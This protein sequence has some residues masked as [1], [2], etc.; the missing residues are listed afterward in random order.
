M[1]I[2]LVLCLL[3]GLYVGAANSLSY[4]PYE[5]YAYQA[6]TGDVVPLNYMK[7]CEPGKSGEENASYV[8][9]GISYPFPARL[10]VAQDFDGDLVV[11]DM[12]DGLPVRVVKPGAFLAC[13]KLKSVSLPGSLREVGDNAFGWCLSLT[14]VTFKSGLNLVGECA[15][16]NCV[17]LTSISFPPTLKKLGLQCF[18]KCNSLEDVYF[19][20]NA[21]QVDPPTKAL[22][23]CLGE[24]LY[25]SASPRSRLRVHVKPVSE[26][27]IA[28][29]VKGVPE[30][31]PVEYGYQNAYETVAWDNSAAD[32]EVRDFV[33]V[34]TEIKGSSVVIPAD[35][36]SRYPFFDM[37]FGTDRSKAVLKRTGKYDAS[38]ADMYVWQ[39]YVAGTDPTDIHDEFKAHI[40]FEN[41][42]VVVSWTPRLSEDETAM[43]KY[44]I[45][46]KRRLSDKTWVE[47]TDDIS[48]Y[49]FFKVIVEMR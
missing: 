45:F 31:W 15:F 7:V 30:K 18:A 43:R 33:T 8:I 23:P 49:N 36:Y 32:G 48:D 46:G 27:W 22:E 28:P 35:W 17:S 39:D 41:G 9:L 5:F 16:S 13:T 34:I 3:I 44:T 2:R 21:P 42:K 40:S 14:N 29:Y 6:D 10:A 37:M 38:G 25:D 12:I 1:G 19:E 47:V 4:P 26:G 11:P 24:K 20:G